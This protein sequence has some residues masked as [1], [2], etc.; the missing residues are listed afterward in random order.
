MIKR[1]CSKCQEEKELTSF[2]VTHNGI[3]STPWCRSCTKLYNA[4]PSTKARTAERNRRRF[5]LKMQDPVYREH[6]RKR[7]LAHYKKQRETD[8][9]RLNFTRLKQRAKQEGTP[10]NLEYEDLPVPEVCPI[11]GITIDR[12]NRDH[13]PSY[14]KIIPSLGYVLGNVAIISCRANRMK[15]NATLDE[16]KALVTYVESHVSQ[17]DE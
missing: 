6:Q 14:D 10:F 15:D 1:K 5:K 8:P 11:L 4:L 13:T 9:N 7:S 12:R 2:Y 17:T 3:V 16:L